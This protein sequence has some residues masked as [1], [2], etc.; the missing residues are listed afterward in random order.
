MNKVHTQVALCTVCLAWSISASAGVMVFKT[1]EFVTAKTAN[2]VS[3]A[4]P[5]VCRT[6]SPAGPVPI[7]Y[8]NIAMS[9]NK[10]AP[11]K[12]KVDAKTTMVKSSG[13]KKST[14]DEAGSLGGVKS[15]KQMDKA[16]F[17]LYSFD[18]KFGGK[19]SIRQSNS[20]IQH[21]TRAP[22]DAAFSVTEVAYTDATGKVFKLQESTLIE[23]TNGEYCAVCM[24]NG[25]VTAIH[26]L[27]AVSPKRRIRRRDKQ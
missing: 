14:G 6:P 26:R 2:G 10:T 22:D 27:L 5:D 16:E 25:Q 7:P 9:S 8:P 3:M 20:T 21:T 24:A 15:S 19:L 23:L 12:T 13:F 18:V 4:F 1:G 11:K 17:A